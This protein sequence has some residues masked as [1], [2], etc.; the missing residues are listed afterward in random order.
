MQALRHLTRPRS[1][2]TA[3]ALG[4][5]A[6]CVPGVAEAGMPQLDV[7]TFPS[8]IVWLLIAFGVLY[9]LMSTLALPR[10]G[11]V[12]EE[13]EIRISSDLEKAE[14]HRDEAQEVQ[15]SYEKALHEAHGEARRL[16]AE[17][18]QS[19]REEEAMALA[20]AAKKDLKRIRTAETKIAKA[21]DAALGSIR[22]VAQETATAAVAKVLGRELDAA[23]VGEAVDRTLERRESDA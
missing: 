11:E 10:V 17:A 16:T 8:Q 5:L 2:V 18:V 19:W 22:D 3:T 23:Q 13:R 6:F 7:S 14:R 20:E 21:R 1:V 9:W 12:L 15:A 4:A